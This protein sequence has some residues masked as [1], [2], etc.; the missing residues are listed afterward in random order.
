[1]LRDYN[2]EDKIVLWE[3]AY[4]QFATLTPNVEAAAWQPSASQQAGVDNPNPAI[5]KAL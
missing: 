4:E 2:I 3:R 1:V 5:A